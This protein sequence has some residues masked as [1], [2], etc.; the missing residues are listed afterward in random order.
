MES[1]DFK[2]EFRI[3]VMKHFEKKAKAGEG[4]TVV[5]PEEEAPQSGDEVI[6]LTALLKRSLK[7]GAKDGAK[8]PAEKTPAKHAA[9]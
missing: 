2:D 8:A 5:K 4:K 9:A 6:A 1:G 7:G 3:Q